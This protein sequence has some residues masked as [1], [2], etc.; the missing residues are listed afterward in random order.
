M[1][2]K[3]EAKSPSPQG[4]ID[5]LGR[6]V[7]PVSV[8]TR[9]KVLH[10]VP[11]FCSWDRLGPSWAEKGSQHGSKLPAK[12]ELKSVKARSKNWS[13]FWCLLE[14]IVSGF[15]AIFGAKNRVMLD[16]RCIKQIDLI[17]KWPK[18]RKIWSNQYNFNKKWGLSDR[19]IEQKSFKKWRLSVAMQD[20]FARWKRVFACH[21][22]SWVQTT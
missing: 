8:A 5:H 6:W 10:R 13:I 9:K 4:G 14:S 16:R 20:C 3:I 12:T 2:P 7:P 17:L 1:G 18:S 22:T 21:I 15:S 11:F 19:K